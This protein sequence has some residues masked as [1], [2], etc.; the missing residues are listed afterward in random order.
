MRVLILGAGGPVAQSAIEAIQGLHQLRLTD[1]KPLK[2]DRHETRVVDVSAPRQVEEAARGMDAII[3]CTVLRNDRTLSWDV[4]TR[5]CY[6]ALRAAVT[7]GIRRFIHTGPQTILGS[8]SGMGNFDFDIDERA[9][10]RPGTGIYSLSKYLA[11]EM[12]AIFAERYD[13]QIIAFYY[14]GFTPMESHSPAA[15]PFRTHPED[16][17]QAFRIALEIQGLPSRLEYFHIA[18]EMPQDQYPITKAKTLLGFQPKHNY[19]HLYLKPRP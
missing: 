11:H 12:L 14:M 7:N 9:P 2:A 19:G 18:G 13:I 10:R 16:A 17:G 5:G 15:V 4:N 8:R 6:N 3:D 1:I